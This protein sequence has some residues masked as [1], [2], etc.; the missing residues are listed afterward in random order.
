MF[1]SLKIVEFDK[2]KGP[3][4][5]SFFGMATA[6]S[7]KICWFFLQT[8]QDHPLIR[9][10]T[11]TRAVLLLVWHRLRTLFFS[12]GYKPYKI[13]H[14]SDYFQELY[15]LAVE[16]IKR[17]MAYVCHQKY[18]ELKGHN[19]PSSPYRDRPIEESLQLFEV[20]CIVLY[21]IVLYCIVCIV[22]YCIVYCIELK[23]HNPPPSP[24]RD[25][26]IEESLQL[27]EVHC[28]VLCC[29]VLYCI[30]LYCIV[31]YNK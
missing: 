22:L 5:P 14:S 1:W 26:P 12:T 9:L 4:C 23:G 31:L 6:K 2:E 7:F 11:T 21:C 20:R 18:E 3:T 17:N 15:D 16:L 29:I 30:V 28:I 8:L 25:R 24:Y 27:F 13:T 19:P 10:Q